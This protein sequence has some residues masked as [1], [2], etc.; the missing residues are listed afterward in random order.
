MEKRY[1]RTMLAT[2]CLPLDAEERVDLPMLRRE[3]RHLRAARLE[4]IYLF[5]TAG[6]GYDVTDAE[7]SEIV[8]TF[9]DEMRG[10]VPMVS[11]ISSSPRHMLE[12]IETA[13][14]L[15]VRDFQL[16]LPCWGTLMDEELAPFFHAMC[17]P[18]PGCRFLLYNIQRAG[19][20]LS[21]AQLER[22]AAEV[23]NL[24]GAKYPAHDTVTLSALAKDS[25]LRYFLTE[26]GYGYGCAV[27]GEFSY[28][29]SI[30][31]SDL[32][33]AHAYFDAGVRG[34][35]DALF[36]LEGDILHAR[37]LIVGAVGAAIDGGYDKVIA[38]LCMPEF[39]LR[40]RK[41]YRYI[42]DAAFARLLA[43]FNE[44]FP[45][46]GVWTKANQERI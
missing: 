42:D 45:A 46:S 28:L 15:G 4:H 13:Y 10:A 19:R 6:E 38:K 9:V 30:G 40:L 7:Y 14:A 20:V 31:V 36:A 11:V 41:P 27:G 17:D 44:E 23:P 18:F 35:M 26:A 12:R 1:E 16:T 8:S 2:A 33:R 3:V 25:P 37:D 22:I 32:P 34:D 29:L 39:P 5:G 21:G 43:Q 24:C